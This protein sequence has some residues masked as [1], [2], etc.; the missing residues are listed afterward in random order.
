[1]V[2]IHLTLDDVIG[3]SNSKELQ[4]K[5]EGK[6][7]YGD[8]LSIKIRSNRRDPRGKNRSRSRSRVA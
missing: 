5:V 2:G 1:M 7:T 3:A 6:N 8:V 4:N